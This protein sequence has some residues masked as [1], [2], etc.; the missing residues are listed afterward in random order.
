MDPISRG[1]EKTRRMSS[2]FALNCFYNVHLPK[3]QQMLIL[4]FSSD[5]PP[6]KSLIVM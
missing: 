5:L 6:A 1:D 3:M 2:G 4:R